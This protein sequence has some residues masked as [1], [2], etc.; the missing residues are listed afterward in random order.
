MWTD[1]L[2]EIM[3]SLN[4][5]STNFVTAATVDL[6]KQANFA[7]LLSPQKVRDKMGLA[8]DDIP[9]PY[10]KQR[11]KEWFELRKTVKVTDSSVYR[12]LVL[13]CV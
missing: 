2:C 4:D 10:L 7:E 13:D 6:N 9:S 11:L 8:N 5:S 1:S 12:A 3:S